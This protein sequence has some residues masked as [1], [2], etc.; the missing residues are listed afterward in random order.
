MPSLCLTVFPQRVTARV[1]LL[2]LSLWCPCIAKQGSSRGHGGPSRSQHLCPEDL[3]GEV[4]GQFMPSPH[5]SPSGSVCPCPGSGWPQPPAF[6]PPPARAPTPWVPGR[7]P[8]WEQ[9]RPPQ[10][11][12]PPPAHPPPRRTLFP[13]ATSG[14][15][16]DPETS[17]AP[18]RRA[19]GRRR[20]R[21]SSPARRALRPGGAR[22]A[23]RSP[24]AALAAW[25]CG[26]RAGE[27][28]R[29]RE[30]RRSPEPSRAEPS[31]GARGSARRAGGEAGPEGGGAGGGR[32]PAR[33]RGRIPAAA[34]GLPRAARCR[35]PPLRALLQPHGKLET[36][37]GSCWR[38]PPSSG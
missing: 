3:L 20:R 26:N 32:G 29:S 33:A 21:P 22:P 38:G 1:S 11:A 10:P 19:A 16:R 35:R 2:P 28:R 8:P 36:W 23:P 7:W 37:T 30:P 13:G 27:P 12:R 14:P 34:A 18:G 17:E 25:A 31:R 9:P 15:A 5:R 24:R 6:T 4:R